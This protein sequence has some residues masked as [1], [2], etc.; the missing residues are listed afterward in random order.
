[1]ILVSRK[2][3]VQLFLQLWAL[4]AVCILLVSVICPLIMANSGHTVYASQEQCS[5]YF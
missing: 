5:L 2:Q 4:P 1:M 3:N